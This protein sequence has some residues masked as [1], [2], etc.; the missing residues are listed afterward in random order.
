[1]I[2]IFDN[3]T[4]ELKEFIPINKNRVRM[5][6]CG[7][8][9]YNYIHIGNA[10]PAVFFDVV[11]RYFMY[12]GY[13]VDFVS[14]ITD[15]DDKIIQRAQEEGVTEQEITQKY[16]EAFL[17]DCAKLG[18][19][20]TTK[21]LYATEY[22]TEI[23]TYIQ[24]LIAAEVAYVVNGSVYFDIA[25]IDVYAELSKQSIAG[26]QI[27]AR[28]EENLEKKSAIDFNLWKP[29]TKGL[30]WDSPWSRGR[31]GWHTECVAMIEAHFGGPIDIHGGGMDL[32][33]P[34]HDNEIAQA[35]ALGCNVL[36]NYWMHNGFVELDTQ[37]MSKS[38]GNFSLATDV[39]EQYGAKAVRFW[40]LSV[41]YSQP[42]AF[43]P[44]ILLETQQIVEKMQQMYE[45]VTTQLKINNYLA[46][47][48]ISSERVYEQQQKF[49]A[50]MNNDFNTANAITT[51]HEITKQMNIHLRQGEKS[52]GVLSQYAMLFSKIDEV[53][54]L[55]LAIEITIDAPTI[56]TYKSWQEAKASKD[57]ITADKHRNALLA[58]NIRVR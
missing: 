3:R 46:K 13:E 25:K 29:T 15:I 22:I 21:R 40:L 12:Q 50:A 54:G 51:L 33:F 11:S 57:F 39:I 36:A 6:V 8:T 31:P 43:S 7:P 14:N 27:G 38:L 42:L 37:K 4:R 41:Q 23:I 20:L 56:Q 5:Y 30:N 44:D 19:C 10:R 16:S 52:Y 49:E 32:K 28:I 34:H 55:N 1:M 18:V 9:V 2:N 53:L 58:K 17:E 47:N 48:L 35:K 26:M 24:R 45:D